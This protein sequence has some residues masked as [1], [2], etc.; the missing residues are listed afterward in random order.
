[1]LLLSYAGESVLLP[2]PNLAVA[3]HSAVGVDQVSLLPPAVLGVEW[4]PGHMTALRTYL[5]WQGPG[6]IWGVK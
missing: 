2:S 3:G 1:M 6:G 4:W 5:S